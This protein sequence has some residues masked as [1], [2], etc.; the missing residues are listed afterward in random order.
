MKRGSLTREPW[1]EGSHAPDFQ[2]FLCLVPIE[3]FIPI[4]TY[5]SE[6]GI[7]EEMCLHE[8]RKDD[9]RREAEGR[10]VDLG[11]GGLKPINV[12]KESIG[13]VKNLET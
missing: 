7:G 1:P 4:A 9:C 11:R 10:T 13:E 6:I 5:Q 3:V 12:R 8:M 2:Q